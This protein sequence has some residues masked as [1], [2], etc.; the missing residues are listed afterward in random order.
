MGPEVKIRAITYDNQCISFVADI[1][2]SELRFEFR[3]CDSVSWQSVCLL[4]HLSDYL[5]PSSALND[6]SM[7]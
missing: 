4:K 7:M 5:G 3:A 6:K 2:N 1:M